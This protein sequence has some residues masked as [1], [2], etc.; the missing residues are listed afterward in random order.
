MQPIK[1]CDWVTDAPL[2][3]AYHDEE[4][5]VPLY[6]EHKLFELLLLEG[7]QA[8]LS[9][10]TVLQKRANYRQ[11]FAGFDIAKVAR[12]TPA[13]IERLMLAEGIIRQRKKLQA[14][15]TN[16]R[17]V[18][19][20]R[21]EWG[22]LTRYLWHFVDYMPLQT[23]YRQQQNVP[24]RTPLSEQLA[25]DLKKRGFQFVGS[26]ICYAFMQ[27]AGLTNDHTQACFRYLPLTQ[28]SVYQECP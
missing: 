9:W 14:A 18:L 16:A 21:E 4:W 19:A 24:A 13:K 22:S 27:A 3:L 20:L 12:F 6:A 15:V 23:H 5:G 25:R 7:A 26:T 11:L 28:K 2:Y 8:G 17:A 1:R 10:W